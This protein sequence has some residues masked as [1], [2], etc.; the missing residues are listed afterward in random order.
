MYIEFSLE[1]I[2][3]PMI[4][5]EQNCEILLFISRE[6]S[7]AGTKRLADK[8]NRVAILMKNGANTNTTCVRV[9]VERPLE[10]G[11]GQYR[12]EL[13]A[14]CRVVKAVCCD[15]VQTN[16]SSFFSNVVSGWA[17]MPK[18]CTNLR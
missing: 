8:G 2:V 1:K 12:A 9:N 3:T 4:D 18:W 17:I 11:K 14:V 5:S 10:V 13:K 15:G 6:T 16:G 7:V